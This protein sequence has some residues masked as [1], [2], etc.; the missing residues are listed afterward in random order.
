MA[1]FGRLGLLG[2]LSL[3]VLLLIVSLFALGF[4]LSFVSS[5]KKLGNQPHFPIPSQIAAI[6]ELLDVTPIE[7][8]SLVLKAIETPEFGAE[9][10]G[11]NLPE[12]FQNERLP[13]IEWLI[14]QY[15]ETHQDR[16]VYAAR[17]LKKSDSFIKSLVN[18]F[19]GNSYSTTL[20]MAVQLKDNQFV[21]F[22]RR[23]LLSLRLVFGIPIG[24]FVGIFGAL[25]A[26]LALWAIAR[27]AKPLKQ[28]S[29]SL[30]EFAETGRPRP[31]K[32][33]GAPEIEK[34]ITAT[35]S[36]QERIAAL[37]KGRTILLGAVSHDL[38]TYITR[39]Q[40][41]VDQIPS[42]EQRD[43]AI[44]D[45][46]EMTQL[47]NDAIAVARG[48]SV[49]GQMQSLDLKQLLLNCAD[50]RAAIKF[51]VQPGDYFISGDET[52]LKRL[53]NNLLDNALHYGNQAIVEMKVLDGFCKISIDDDGPG[54]SEEHRLTVFEPFY[55]VEGSRNR[56]FGGS[57]LGL[58]IVKQI[59]DNHCGRIEISD[60][61]QGGARFTVVLPSENSN[62]STS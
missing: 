21:L 26:A 31:I 23:Q 19:Y 17:E 13:G 60:S 10:I 35:N 40:L 42:D 30:N 14:G 1:I 7:Q 16:A 32:T 6:S 59:I 62:V 38:K 53:F 28:L 56:Q 27:E 57:G 4:G 2:R 29:T 20:K 18:R 11:Q 47:I 36:M 5:E 58:A 50:D 61:Q 3:I 43:K 24:F 45:L 9:L 44:N 54:I 39:L 37:I 12:I 41:R 48:V 25:F 8:R 22:E 33:S 15:L 34:L 49:D 52:A 55:R 46:D 51:I